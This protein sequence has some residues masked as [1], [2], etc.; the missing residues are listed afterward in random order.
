MAQRK[1]AKDSLDLF[2]TPP[3]ATR[4]LCERLAADDPDLKT[5]TFWEPA[6]GNGD[7]LKVLWEYFGAGIGSDVY[8]HKA[9]TVTH[10][11]LMPSEPLCRPHWIITNPPFRLAEQFIERSFG[12]ATIGVA[13]LVRLSFLEGIGRYER[14]FSKN[15]PTIAQFT[16]RVTMVKGRLDESGGSATAYC[17]LVWN[18]DFPPIAPAVGLFGWIPPCRKRLERA[19]DYVVTA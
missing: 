19:A 16:E 17:W 18:K 12:L 3:W 7:M 6:C 9:G 15:P 2:P 11:F 10:D 14:L 8:A 13:M 5:K 4:A 1:E